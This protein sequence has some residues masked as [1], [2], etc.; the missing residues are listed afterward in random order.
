MGKIKEIK[1][2]DGKGR[3][4]EVKTGNGSD[5]IIRLKTSKQ[6]MVGVRF[7]KTKQRVVGVHLKKKSNAYFRVGLRNQKGERSFT[8]KKVKTADG[9]VS[10]QKRSKQQLVMVRLKKSK[11]RVV[12]DV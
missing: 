11:Q 8:F 7:K 10:Y 3:I 6:R 1:T 2:S 5:Q 4:K 9:H 12:H